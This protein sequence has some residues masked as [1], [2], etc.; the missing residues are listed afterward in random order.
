VL[1][2]NSLRIVVLDD[3][4]EEEEKEIIEEEVIK[5]EAVKREGKEYIV[6]PA[7]FIASFDL[8]AY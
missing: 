1:S 8:I 2:R 6:T 4:E 3:K 5:G 7:R